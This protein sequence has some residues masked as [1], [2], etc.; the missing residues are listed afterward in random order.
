MTFNRAPGESSSPACTP[1]PNISL[2]VLMRPGQGRGRG[3]SIGVILLVNSQPSS[4]SSLSPPS[5]Y[6]SCPQVPDFSFFKKK[7]EALKTRIQGALPPRI[8]A[9]T[10]VSYHPRNL[11]LHTYTKTQVRKKCRRGGSRYYASGVGTGLT[12]SASISFSLASFWAGVALQEVILG[13]TSGKIWCLVQDTL[14]K[15][16]LWTGC[17]SLESVRSSHPSLLPFSWT[18]QFHAH[19]CSKTEGKLI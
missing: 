3:K 6:A 18:G 12:Q 13:F 19:L 14:G 15:D 2:L 16:H 9:R 7:R 11:A 10:R 4:L 1:Q 5:K 8:S 17:S